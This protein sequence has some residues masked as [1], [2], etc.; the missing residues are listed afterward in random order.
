[1][2]LESKQKIYVK[3]RSGFDTLLAAGTIGDNHL[4]FIEDTQEVWTHGTFFSGRAFKSISDGTNIAASPSTTG[5]ITFNGSG[6]STV[7]VGSSGV[8]VSSTDQSVTAVGNHYAPVADAGSEL[9]A[10]AGTASSYTLGT[11]YSVVTGV[12]AQR[13]AKGH[14]TGLTLTTQKVKDTNSASLQIS[15]TSNKKINTSETTGN[16]IQFT[17]GTN[18][19]T[20]TD[21]SGNT[22]DV[23]VSATSDSVTGTGLTADKIVL[24]DGSSAIKTSSKGIETALTA[25]SN[26]ALPTSKAVADYVA[27]SLTSALKYK[28]TVGTSPATV[29]SLPATH[30]VGDVYV[31]ATAGTYAGKACEVGDYIIC[32][33]DGTTATD[34]HWDAVNGEN[35]V[36]NKS[37]NL[38][39]PGSSATIA[40]VDGTDL[41]VGTPSTWE[42]TDTKVTA[43]SNH[44]APSADANSELTASLSGTAGSYALNTEYTVLTGVKAQRDAKGHVTGLTYTA[45]KIKDTQVTPGDKALKVASGSGT[46]TTAITMNEGSADKTLTITGDGTW[47]TG[48]VSGSTGAPTV[49]LSHGGPDTGA[50]LTTSNG[51]ASAYSLNTEYTVITGVTVSADSKG[52]ITGVSTTRQK[53]KDTNTTVGSGITLTGYSKAN[54]ASAV[55]AT[56]TVNQ[57]IGKLEYKL[58]ATSEWAEYD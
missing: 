48:A 16:F 58:D 42:V 43:V 26:D 10:T 2:A 36:S 39:A 14:V 31:V 40:T 12:K 18:K 38:A 41:T 22:F 37:A 15:D 21:K 53:I 28:G 24:G 54:A 45:Q 25:S 35:Q 56:D 19:F 27:T 50:A 52:H 34:S 8:T 46:A 4:V 57:A 3:T 7:T 6:A 11:E 30:K 44:Y 29:Q 55:A 5:I 33:T 13:D 1:M 51:T 32:N 20:I 23:P 49:T 47:I 9:T 17:G